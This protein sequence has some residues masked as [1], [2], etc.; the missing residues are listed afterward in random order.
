MTYWASHHITTISWVHREWAWKGSSKKAWGQRSQWAN[1]YSTTQPPQ[2][3]CC[4]QDLQNCCTCFATACFSPVSLFWVLGVEGRSKEG[5][6][7]NIGS[8]WKMEDDENVLLGCFHF[9]A[10]NQPD[11]WLHLLKDKIPSTWLWRG[12]LRRM[13]FRHCSCGEL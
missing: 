13:F 7:G 4:K 10:R 3:I 11:N 2:T 8:R 1:W 5:R 9:T 6:F 12:G